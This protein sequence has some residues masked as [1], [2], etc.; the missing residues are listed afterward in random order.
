[1]VVNAISTR[2]CLQEDHVFPEIWVDP[3][4]W[5]PLEP[6]SKDPNSIATSFSSR[7]LYAGP[8]ITVN[9]AMLDASLQLD[10]DLSGLAQTFLTTSFASGRA[11]KSAITPS[12]ADQLADFLEKKAIPSAGALQKITQIYPRRRTQEILLYPQHAKLGSSLAETR[13][14]FSPHDLKISGFWMYFGREDKGIPAD[15][16]KNEE[17]EEEGKDKP[18]TALLVSLDGQ[19]PL[20]RVI[21]GSALSAGPWKYEDKINR[22]GVIDRCPQDAFL[23]KYG[24]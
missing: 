19:R 23:Q 22:P 10:L 13:I 17:E 2:T 12:F 4:G 7:L 1:M 5:V 24:H 21:T 18:E 11:D 14:I 15:W 6:T 20:E 9:L 8:A 16:E 3:T